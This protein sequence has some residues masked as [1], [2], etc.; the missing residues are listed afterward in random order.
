MMPLAANRCS[1]GAIVSHVVILTDGTGSGSVAIVHDYLNQRGGAERVVLEMARIWPEAQLYTSLYRPE[2]VFPEFRDLKVSTTFVDRVPVD[3]GFRIIAP[4]LPLAFRSIPVLEHDLVI[5]SSS[6]WAH[7]VRTGDRATHVV[8]CYA[9]ARWLYSADRYLQRRVQRV[10]MAPVSAMLKRWDRGAANRATRY[11]AIAGNVRDRIRAAYG[12]DA[13][14][15]YP[16]VDTDKFSP[17]PRGN[18][19]LCISRLLPY[20][21]IDLMVETATS[22]GIGLD[23]VG[24]GPVR[25]ELRE[26]AGPSVEFHGSISD[27]AL[28]EL[29]HGCSAVCMPGTE[30]FGIAPLEGNAAGKPALAFAAGGALETI[31]EGANGV[32]FAEPTVKCVADAISRLDRLQTSPED[33]ARSAQRFSVERFRE[34]LIAAVLRAVQQ[35][36]ASRQLTSSLGAIPIAHPGTSPSR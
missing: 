9:P 14:V 34:S 10:A 3:S 29:V 23:I 24:D 25:N 35:N 26:I 18:R 1:A 17:S 19:L 27:E 21:R 8:Y 22:L 11:I 15:V 12:I 6:G 30:D 5:S 16:P 28:S 7:S 33:L 36:P 4:L 32:L 20:K 13:D 2:S 31:Q